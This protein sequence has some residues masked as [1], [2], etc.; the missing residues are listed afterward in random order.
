MTAKWNTYYSATALLD[1]QNNDKLLLS[2]EHNQKTTISRLKKTCLQCK[3]AQI[4]CFSFPVDL[5]Q[6]QQCHL[7]S[8]RS[9]DCNLPIKNGRKISREYEGSFLP[10]LL[11]PVTPSCLNP[12]SL[13]NALWPKFEIITRPYK[14]IILMC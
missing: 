13:S 5:H 4:S 11:Q 7:F 8:K 10:L 2:N 12:P 9:F 14:F 1:C 3:I 6:L